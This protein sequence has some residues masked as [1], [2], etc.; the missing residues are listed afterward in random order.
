[1]DGC[2][3]WRNYDD[4][5]CNWGSLSDII[6]HWGTRVCVCVRAREGA[7]IWPTHHAP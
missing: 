5:Q 2:N 6:D 3:L 1:M 4:I 7:I